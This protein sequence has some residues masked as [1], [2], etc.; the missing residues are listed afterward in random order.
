MGLSTSYTERHRPT[1]PSSPTDEPID[2]S[3]PAWA[4]I[5][6]TLSRV[7]SLPTEPPQ[8]H[9]LAP[10]IYKETMAIG[11]K[12]YQQGDYQTAL[13]NFRRALSEKVGD[14]YATEAIANTEAIIQKQRDEA[15]TASET[16]APD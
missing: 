5:V 13:I 4:V 6:P 1:A 7:R 12:A 10:S 11:Y 16:E 14:R 3:Q 8:R 9:P 15:Q 2:F